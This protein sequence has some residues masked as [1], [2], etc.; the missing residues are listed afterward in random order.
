MNLKSSVKYNLSSLK[1]DALLY[2]FWR[3]VV[4]DLLGKVVPKLYIIDVSGFIDK[5]ELFLNRIPINV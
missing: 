3:V 2:K 4:L 5:F 1:M